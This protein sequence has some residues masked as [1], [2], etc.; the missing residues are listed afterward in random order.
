[1]AGENRDYNAEMLQRSQ[2]YAGFLLAT[3]KHRLHSEPT[4][5]K[6]AAQKNTHTAG[7]SIGLDLLGAFLA[8]LALYLIVPYIIMFFT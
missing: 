4:H 7:S 6:S 5:V 2:D 1:M 3:G 8:F